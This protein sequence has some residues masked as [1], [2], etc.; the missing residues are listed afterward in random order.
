MRHCTR[1]TESQRT[2]EQARST[3]FIIWV[4]YVWLGHV[5]HV[6]MSHGLHVIEWRRTF[7]QA[8]STN[9]SRH[10]YVNESQP[11]VWIG[12][13]THM[14]KQDQGGCTHYLCMN[15]SRHT[16]MNE[17]WPMTH[18]CKCAVIPT[19]HSPRMNK[20]EQDSYMHRVYELVTAHIHSWVMACYV[21]ESWCTYKWIVS[22]RLNLFSWWVVDIKRTS[23][24]NTTKI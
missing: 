5:T 10:T 20:Q 14:N 17:S 3:A 16:Y 6:S 18:S 8:R 7:E 22:K 2:C 11:T 12:H 15:E 9:E 21:D 23:R 24:K 1:A 4:T 19:R 13:D